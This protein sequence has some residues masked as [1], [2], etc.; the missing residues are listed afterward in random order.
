MS[1]TLEIPKA[2]PFGNYRRQMVRAYPGLLIKFNKGDWVVGKDGDVLPTGS[3]LVA[4]MNSLMIGWQCWQGGEPVETMMGLYIEGFMP[5]KRRDLSDTDKSLWEIG[6]NGESRDPWAYT[7]ALPFVSEDMKAIYTF[8]TSSLGGRTAVD[9]LAVDHSRT[10]PGQYPVVSLET[11]SYMHS[12]REIGRV[13][14][15]L[16][17]IVGRVDAEPYDRV[18]AQALG[19]NRAP[20]IEMPEALPERHSAAGITYMAPAASHDAFA[21]VDPDDQ[22]P[23]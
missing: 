7:N 11:S 3:R 14:T 22:I 8:T 13:K 18:I 9:D 5:A 21:G 17:R 6:V 15:P 23:F 2:N 10:P 19:S 20:A 12:K 16:F 1:N 4:A